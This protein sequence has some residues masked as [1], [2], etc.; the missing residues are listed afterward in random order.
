MASE[1]ILEQK[2]QEVSEIVEILKS[3]QGV[4][5]SEYQGIQVDKDTQMRKEMRE[6]GVTYKVVKNATLIHAFNQMG[7]KGFEEDLKGP[8]A[9][10]CSQDPVAPSKL[11]SKYAKQI[12]KIKIKSGVLEGARI[13]IDKVNQLATLPSKEELIAKV[14]SGFNAP[15]YGLV[16][17]LNGNL[18]GLVVALNAIVEKRQEADAS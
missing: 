8:N 5:L 9:I 15:L 12:D 1:K 16:N 14:V 10:A 18:R 13:D 2:K 3:S 4:V 7:Y 11:M 17:V 6:A